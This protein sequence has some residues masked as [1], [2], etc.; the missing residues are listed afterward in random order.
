MNPS[1]V[2]EIILS[3]YQ[4][5]TVKIEVRGTSYTS[6]EAPPRP[7]GVKKKGNMTHT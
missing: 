5:T 1:H 7:S 2:R 4:R 6:V 3:L